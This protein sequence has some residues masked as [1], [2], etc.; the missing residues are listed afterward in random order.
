VYPLPFGN[1][2]GSSGSFSIEERPASPNDPGPHADN[3]WATAGYLQAMEIPLLRGRWFSDEDDAGHP[4]VVVIDETLARAYWPGQN[5]IGKHVRSG[6]S[7]AEWE[8]IVG[9]VGHVRRDSLEVDENK[10]VVYRSMAQDPV[11]EA[12]FLVRTS[13]NPDAMRSTIAET[14]RGADSQE[15]VY[16]VRSLDSLVNDSLAAR[17]LLVGLLTLFGGL[18]LLLAAIGIYGLLSFSAAQRTTEI[19]IRMALGAQRWQVVSLVLRQSF[20]LI[21]IGIV[22]GLVLTFAAQRI[23]THAFAAMN[24]GM[25]V[26]LFVAAMS[27]LLMAGLAAAIPA[28]RSASVDPVVALR[29]E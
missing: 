21:G 28:N 13:I 25:S 14:V 7:K 9:V 11:G 15:A 23:L 6:G 20:Q 12:S 27:L 29:N 17:R 16:D 4:N 3:R 18:A 5:P 26:S 24:T 22:A 19:G 1:A 10:G 8:E 2:G